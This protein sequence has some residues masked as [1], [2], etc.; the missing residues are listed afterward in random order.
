MKE[1]GSKTIAEYEYRILFL[2][3]RLKNVLNIVEN[4]ISGNVEKA[5][6]SLNDYKESTEYSLLDKLIEKAD[7]D[8]TY[9]FLKIIIES[10]PFPVFMKD[11]NGRYIFVNALEADLF[12]L[13]ESSI[14]GKHDSDFVRNE[15]EMRIIKE[16]DAE[17]LERN[18]SVE[19]PNQKFSLSDGKSY[20]F[21]T[22]KIPFINPLSGK[23]NI[24]GFSVDVTDAVNLDRLRTVVSRLNNPYL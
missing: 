5:R 15:E 23:R 7:Y 10:M 13:S 11:E 3:K 2:E 14:I 20:V 17:V 18:A 6:I 24:L 16:S 12:G 22:H 1:T 8:K 19:L 21:K 4:V 9:V